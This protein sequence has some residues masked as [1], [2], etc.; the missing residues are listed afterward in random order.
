MMLHGKEIEARKTA[1]SIVVPTL[2]EAE[3]IGTLIHRCLRET[4]GLDVEIIVMDD[5]SKDG[6]A[7][8]VNAIAS[9]HP[10]RLIERAD[11]VNG[12]TGAILAGAR[13][14]RHDIVVVMDADLSHPPDRIL[15]LIAPI[16]AGEKDMV[17]GSRYIPGGRTPGW[18]WQRRMMSR[19]ASSLARPLTHVRDCL[20]GFFA[21]RRKFITQLA[22]DAAG[23]KVALEILVRSGR[24]LRVAEIPIIFRDRE[25]GVSKMNGRVAVTYLRRLI[26]LFCVSI[27]GNRKAPVLVESVEG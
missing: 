9:T 6:T 22:P 23:F 26:V 4:A 15:D 8:R 21:V 17:I 25:R 11:P 1:I 27:F 2:D 3:N 10:V 16:A 12:L 14:A 20:S 5:G 19:A 24:S 13:A 18:P 7:E